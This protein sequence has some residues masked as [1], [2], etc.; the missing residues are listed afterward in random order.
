MYKGARVR[1]QISFLVKIHGV[2][3]ESSRDF[4]DKNVFPGV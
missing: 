1:I 2:Y 3:K 4:R